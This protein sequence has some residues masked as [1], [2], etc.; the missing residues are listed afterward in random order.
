MM[1]KKLYPG[2]N[3]GD[4]EEEHRGGAEGGDG[5]CD[6]GLD[7]P[8]KRPAWEIRGSQRMEGGMERKIMKRRHEEEEGFMVGM[9]DGVCKGESKRG[10]LVLWREGIYYYCR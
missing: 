1:A 8:Q 6:T 3:G 9:I 2:E 7:V 4:N 10:Y 5:R